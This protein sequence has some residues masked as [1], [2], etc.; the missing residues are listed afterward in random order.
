MPEAGLNAGHYTT[1]HMELLEGNRSHSYQGDAF[2]AIRSTSPSP[3]PPHWPARGEC[4]LSIYTFISGGSTYPYKDLDGRSPVRIEQNSYYHNLVGN[5]LGF[6]GQTLLTYSGS[7]TTIRRPLDIRG[8][9]RRSGHGGADVEDRFRR[10]RPTR[11]P[12]VG[13]SDREHDPARRQLGLG[14]R[15]AAVARDRRRAGLQ[16]T[17]RHSQLALL[18]QKPAFFGSNPWPWVDPSTGAVYTLP[19][20]AR[21]DAMPVSPGAAAN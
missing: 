3:Q 5:V 4:P 19:A 1:P 9:C 6:Q 10:L 15:L 18:S 16:N 12:P 20:K 11:V 13:C 2:W 14:D 8:P 21:F 17:H 7:V